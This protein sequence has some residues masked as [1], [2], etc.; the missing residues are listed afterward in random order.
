MK[1]GYNQLHKYSEIFGKKFDIPVDH[2]VLKRNFYS[3]AQALKDKEHRKQT[4]NVFSLNKKITGK[5]VLLIDDVYT[6]GNTAA[7]IAWEIYGNAEN[8]VSLLVM[9]N[10]L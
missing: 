3:K 7:N 9:A 1:R 4:A 6:T 8:K 2:E 10:E 5:H